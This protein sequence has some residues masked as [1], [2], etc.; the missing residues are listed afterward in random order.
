VFTLS[1]VVD[2]PHC[3]DA[4][5]GPALFTVLGICS[6]ACLAIASRLSRAELCALR[7]ALYQQQ[8]PGKWPLERSATKFSSTC[9][10]NGKSILHVT[11]MF[12]SPTRVLFSG[13]CVQIHRSERKKRRWSYSIPL[14]PGQR[15]PHQC[16]KRLRPASR[17]GEFYGHTDSVSSYLT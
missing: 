8:C 13:C 5:E 6:L 17:F 7:G 1:V 12:S 10:R 3:D 2:Y 14:G 15:E 16:N 9:S 11:V 4:L